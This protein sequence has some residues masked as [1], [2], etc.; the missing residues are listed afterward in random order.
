MIQLNFA[1]TYLFGT[2]PP[3]TLCKIKV[4]IL[5]FG[6]QE[7]SSKMH[8]NLN[9]KNVSISRVK[10]KKQKEKF[11]L[12]VSLIWTYLFDIF[13]FRNTAAYYITSGCKTRHNCTLF[14]FFLL[15]LLQAQQR[16]VEYWIQI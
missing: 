15:L 13:A 10:A 6:R 12:L 14:S 8:T 11:R 9:V 16:T 2:N 1:F 7:P 4:S 3:K 5:F